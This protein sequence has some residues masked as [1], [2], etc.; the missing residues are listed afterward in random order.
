MYVK[1]YFLRRSV[2]PQIESRSAFSSSVS[3]RRAI[4]LRRTGAAKSFG[5]PSF[6]S[7][8]LGFFR[9]T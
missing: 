6:R 1:L 7:P 2:R 3:S 5:T 9:P 4:A 8:F